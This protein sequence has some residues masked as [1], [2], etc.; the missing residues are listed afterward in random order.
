VGEYECEVAITTENGAV[1]AVGER[2]CGRHE[3][4]EDADEQCAQGGGCG[5]E[6]GGGGCGGGEEGSEAIEEV[7]KACKKS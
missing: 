7:K 6:C 5:C 3:E 4:M 1:D 2:E